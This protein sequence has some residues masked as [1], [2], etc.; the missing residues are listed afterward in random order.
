[1]EA[2]QEPLCIIDENGRS[3]HN[4]RKTHVLTYLIYAGH[5]VIKFHYVLIRVNSAIVYSGSYA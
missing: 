5:Y 4:S 3:V 2:I 1:M